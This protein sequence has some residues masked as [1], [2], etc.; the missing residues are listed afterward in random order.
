MSEL[1]V[2]PALN[3]L[4]LGKSSWHRENCPFLPL[5]LSGSFTW[6]KGQPR[7]AQMGRRMVTRTQSGR[8]CE[9]YAQAL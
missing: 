5:N 2:P 8:E 7:K 3:G 9:L 4:R 1:T 6:T